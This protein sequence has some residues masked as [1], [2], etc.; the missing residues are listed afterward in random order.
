MAKDLSTLGVLAL[1]VVFCAGDLGAAPKEPIPSTK[2]IAVVCALE[3]GFAGQKIG[4]TSFTNDSW[5]EEDPGV[6]VNTILLDSTKHYL[7]RE[8]KVVN[9]QEVGMT[10]K[11]NGKDFASPLPDAEKGKGFKEQMKGKLGELGR[12]WNVDVIV[13]VHTVQTND[14]LQRTPVPLP[15]VGHLDAH[16]GGAF[17]ALQMRVFDCRTGALS[18]GPKVQR[19]RKLPDIQWHVNWNEYT[20]GEQRAFVRIL[21]VLL[22]ETTGQLLT[23]SGLSRIPVKEPERKG[24]RQDARIPFVPEGNVIAIP[25]DLP[26]SAG[27]DAVLYAFK[28]EEWKTTLDTPEKIAAVY[29]N[30]EDEAVCTVTFDGGNIILAPEGFEYTKDGK[31]VQV[32]VHNGWHEDLKEKIVVFLLKAPSENEAKCGAPAA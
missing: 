22:D 14:F 25:P 20:P 24:F 4:V 7:N 30:D 8:A 16:F 10:I 3:P 17:C 2:S 15:G 6:D 19:A 32:G 13:V 28:E 12:L 31:R 9:G 18:Q 26:V 27:R 5:A 1:A 29:R 21:R 11:R 23:E